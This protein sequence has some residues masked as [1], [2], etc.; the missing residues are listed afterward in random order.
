MLLLVGITSHSHAQAFPDTL[1]PPSP[2]IPLEVFVTPNNLLVQF[3]ISKP[4]APKSRFGFFNVT[5]FTGDYREQQKNQY[6]SQAFLTASI[7]RG[8]SV[9]AGVSMNYQT[10]FSP[11][12]GLQYVLATRQLL[13]VVL[14]RIDLSA[15]YNVEFFGLLEYHPSFGKHWGLYTR[16][17]ALYNHNTRLGFHERS[18]GQLRI[19]ATYDHF[20]FGIGGN[21]DFYGPD[22]I[23]ELSLGL[24]LR[25]EIF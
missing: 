13:V 15:T 25:T 24:F 16:L 7:W 17:Q 22:R 6:L 11:S 3:I 5:N 18:Y 20:Q 9:N 10:G 1:P 2:P 21:L 8:L 14:P 12:A 23:Q 19:G 4:L